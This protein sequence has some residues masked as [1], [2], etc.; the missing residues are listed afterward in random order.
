MI[1]DSSIRTDLDPS[2]RLR[3]HVGRPDGLPVELSQAVP[4]P[5]Q[6]LRHVLRSS[7]S[8]RSA[9]GDGRPARRLSRHRRRSRRRPSPTR[10]SRPA[11]ADALDPGAA[12]P[13]HRGH[14]VPRLVVHA[15]RT[16]TRERSRRRGAGHLL[17]RPTPTGWSGSVAQAHP[18]GY[19]DFT[20]GYWS[21]PPASLATLR[22]QHR[23]RRWTMSNGK[24]SPQ[25]D[26]VIVGAGVSGNLIAKQLGLAGK[27]V[28]ILEAGPPVPD[29]REEYMEN[30]YLALAK[31][32]ESPYPS[33]A[34]RTGSQVIPSASCPI[35]PRSRRRARRCSAIGAAARSRAHLHPIPD[36]RR[37]RPTRQG[38][39]R[40]LQ[41]S[42]TYERIGG[43]T[44]WHWLGTSLRELVQNDMPH[45]DDVR[46]CRRTGR[47][48]TTSC[49]RCGRWPR[50]RS[51]SPRSVAQQEPLEVASACSIRR[52]INTR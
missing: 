28:L 35:R 16:R 31:T 3:E 34:G 47:S 39:V 52:A 1:D 2:S 43:G 48:P 45:E 9:S 42:S 36:R 20:F 24:A 27:K 14:V 11:S 29:S 19:S 32:P 38:D 40:D 44:A 41:F 17:G 8:R 6:S 26:V 33:L 23:Q 12:R 30:F 21:Q 15:R 7:P 25:Y 46:L 50:K 37:R 13:E 4:R 18:M 49:R 10:C 51:A 5:R 22:R